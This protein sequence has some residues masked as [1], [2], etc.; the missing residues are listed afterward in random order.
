[1]L[2]YYIGPTLLYCIGYFLVNMYLLYFYN[3]LVQDLSPMYQSF[4]W[5]QF[6]EKQLNGIYGGANW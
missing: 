5:L 6:Y 4:A 2:H 3:V 1:M